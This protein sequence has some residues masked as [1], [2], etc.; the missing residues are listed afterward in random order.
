MILK[1][2]LCREEAEKRSESWSE[3]WGENDGEASGG[4]QGEADGSDATHV[5]C[6]PFMDTWA[7]DSE[8]L[9]LACCYIRIW[10]GT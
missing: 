6:D 5:R 1:D 2:T 8:M 10:P 4:R 3:G 9:L 7:S